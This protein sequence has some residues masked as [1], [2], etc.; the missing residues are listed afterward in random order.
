[1]SVLSANLEVALEV[2]VSPNVKRYLNIA[3]NKSGDLARLIREL[4]AVGNMETQ[5]YNLNWFSLTALL[6]G[7]AAK[8]T[9]QMDTAE[10]SLNI[11]YRQDCQVFIDEN[12]IWR[13]FDNILGNAQRYT[14][15]N[16]SITISSSEIKDGFVSVCVSDNGCGIAIKDLPHIFEQYY[17]ADKSRGAKGAGLGLYIVKTAIE[18]M[19][20]NVTAESEPGKG[21]KIIFSLKARL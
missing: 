16:G 12:Y 21:T 6:T 8:Y 10:I 9:E 1:M 11:N 4:L 5:T 13:V 14:P 15:K 3:Y 20:G 17:K 2:E 18:A 19:G 7:V